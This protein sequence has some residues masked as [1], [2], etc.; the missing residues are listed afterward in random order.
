MLSVGRPWVLGTGGAVALVVAG[1]GSSG[2][3]KN[4]PRPPAAINV[5]AEISRDRVSVSPDHFGAGPI[6]LTITNQTGATQRIL[7][8]PRG[9]A[10][11]EKQATAPIAPRDTAELKADLASGRYSI[12][13]STNGIHSAVLHVGRERPSAQNQ[14][15]QP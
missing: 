2:S 3:Y 11:A 15:L 7:L 10:G 1:C 9:G 14:L 8:E 5:S 12:R 13:V 4:L 6:D